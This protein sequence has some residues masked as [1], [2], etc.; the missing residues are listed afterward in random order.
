MAEG[1]ESRKKIYKITGRQLTLN[2]HTRP[3]SGPAPQ[4]VTKIAPSG[5]GQ[6]PRTK[7]LPSSVVGVARAFRKG[8][9]DVEGHNVAVEFRF[10]EAPS[11]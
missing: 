7:G 10:S 2:A 8:L 11:L 9:E 6:R 3:N 4:P 1:A 5:S